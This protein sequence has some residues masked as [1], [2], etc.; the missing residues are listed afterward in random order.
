M[1]KIYEY[2]VL[3]IDLSN[4]EIKR[5]K[6]EGEVVKKYLGGRGLAS[7]ILYDEIDP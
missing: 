5:E 2:E 7:K 4:E 3:R 1:G 6:I